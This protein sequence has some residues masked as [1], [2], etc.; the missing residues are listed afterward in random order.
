MQIKGQEFFKSFFLSL[1]AFLW[2]IAVACSLLFASENL[3]VF[4]RDFFNTGH[5]FYLLIALFWLFFPLQKIFTFAAQKI[6]KRK[7]YGKYFLDTLFLLNIAF[8]LWSNYGF[9]EGILAYLYSYPILFSVQFAFFYFFLGSRILYLRT[10]KV[11][12]FAGVFSI[13]ALH[14]FAETENLKAFTNTL[15]INSDIFS[16]SFSLSSLPWTFLWAFL[17]WFF[18][19]L[20]VIFTRM[21]T[22]EEIFRVYKPF[23]QHRYL[24]YFLD[25]LRYFSLAAVFVDV[26]SSLRASFLPLLL[27]TVG[28]TLK[29]L[30]LQKNIS[31]P[32][33]KSSLILSYSFLLTFLL[34]AA[35]PLRIWMAFLY[36]LLSLW[37]T[38]FFPQTK[39]ERGKI[40][41]FLSGEIIL[42]FFLLQFFR[43]PW[44]TTI[45][46]AIVFMTLLYFVFH[47]IRLYRFT[48]SLLFVISAVAW[49]ILGYR[50]LQKS[51]SVELLRPRERHEYSPFFLAYLWEFPSTLNLYT[52]ALPFSV[53]DH[54]NDD[55]NNSTD[56][57]KFLVIKQNWSS[58]FLPS[59]LRTSDK[60]TFYLINMKMLE[61]YRDTKKGKILLQSIRKNKN[62]TALAFFD[63]HE[64][65]SFYQIE[66][67]KMVERKLQD[68]KI[69][70]FSDTLSKDTDSEN[71]YKKQRLYQIGLDLGA[72]FNR[73][74]DFADALFVYQQ[75]LPWFSDD[76][77]LYK[78]L[79][80]TCG[81]IG[82]LNLQIYYLQKFLTYN[83]DFSLKE[84]RT[85]MELF[86]I[87]GDYKQSRE[88]A[89]RLINLDKKHKWEYF[90]FIFRIVKNS[91]REYQWKKFYYRV[92]AASVEKDS[93]QER[94]KL[95]LVNS[96]EKFIAQHPDVLE[97][98]KKEKVRQEHIQIPEF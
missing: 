68:I 17:A 62:I 20:F 7:Q 13:L 67:G 93:Q 95:A 3:F 80:K 15:R 82:A 22:E 30:L 76:A 21:Q 48:A 79:S 16:T 34:A 59:L 89:E 64:S 1:S 4:Y 53:N 19:E 96:I 78:R 55:N 54:L 28:F 65:S 36:V 35:F 23:Y 61:A 49:G 6:F 91:E 9:K 18:S 50:Q 77:L 25:F 94:E 40:D 45:A 51:V 12:L 44:F 83:S 97:I 14:E 84:E 92:L 32:P 46:L 8:L 31:W 74:S 58:L 86:F 60:K 42:L 37:G 10:A 11:F 87:R 43:Y 56:E 5:F 90:K 71:L 70:L 69:P 73:H 63:N 33:R 72:Y 66:R 75:L 88:I 47:Y 29:H 85:L 2:G 41:L 57:E 52:N 81:N 27:L 39:K 98:I 24:L 38:I 26:L